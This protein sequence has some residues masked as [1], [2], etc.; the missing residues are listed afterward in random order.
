MPI[1]T[2]TK[3]DYNLI[4]LLDEV[5]SAITKQFYAIE[6]GDVL[7][8]YA[9][10]NGNQINFVL[11]DALDGSE[12]SLLSATVVAHVSDS[13]YMNESMSNVDFT[14]NNFN[15]ASL[16]SITISSSVFF[17]GTTPL[18]TIIGTIISSYSFSGGGLLPVFSEQYGIN[19]TYIGYGTESACKILRVISSGATYESLWAEDSQTLSKVWSARTSY[20]YF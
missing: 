15:S 2:Y 14:R 10:S 13:D 18:E 6:E 20:N 9:D 1:Y 11:N 7:D 8:G 16:T 12:E 4:Q 3:N 17:S 5:Y 19:K